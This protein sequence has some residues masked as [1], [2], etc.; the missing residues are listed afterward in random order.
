MNLSIAL[1]LALIGLFVWVW[2]IIIP[3]TWLV[4]KRRV[5]GKKLAFWLSSVLAGYV[6]MFGIFSLGQYIL[7]HFIGIDR[8]THAIEPYVAYYWTGFAVIAAI[9]LC[10]PVISTYF[11]YSKYKLG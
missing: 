6:L 11:L 3:S 10:L 5:I 7:V 2:P 8:L 9:I 1:A 4:W